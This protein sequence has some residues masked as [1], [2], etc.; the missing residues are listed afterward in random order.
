[1]QRREVPFMTGDA[2]NTEDK[3]S[4]GRSNVFLTATL[5]SGTGPVLVRIR[6]ISTSGVLVDGA[7]LPSVG[8]KVRLS[9]GELSVTGELVWQGTRQ[10]GINFAENIDVDRWVQKAGHPGQQRVDGIM[11]ALRRSERVPDEL[12]E[13]PTGSLMEISKALDQVCQRLAAMPNMSTDLGEALLR[14]DSLAQSLRDI[15]TGRR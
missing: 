6:N 7:S 2:L 11:A 14:L 8:T 9:R 10:G 12:Q 15:A 1:M 13:V 5:D 3:R 4:E